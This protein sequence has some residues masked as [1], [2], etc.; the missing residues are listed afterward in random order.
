MAGPWHL[1]LGCRRRR[2]HDAD[3]GTGAC[4]LR[5]GEM[6]QRARLSPVRGRLGFD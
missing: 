2:L 4:R 5:A 3:D 1:P 6:R